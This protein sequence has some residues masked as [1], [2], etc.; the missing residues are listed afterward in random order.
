MAPI[1][2]LL[3]IELIKHKRLVPGPAETQ[4]LEV[5]LGSYFDAGRTTTEPNN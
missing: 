3:D 4:A 1:S 2:H 5:D